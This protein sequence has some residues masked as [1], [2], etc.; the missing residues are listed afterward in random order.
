MRNS[1][2]LKELMYVIHSMGKSAHAIALAA[3]DENL[4]EKSRADYKNKWD[5]EQRANACESIANYLVEVA[6]TKLTEA[7]EQGNEP[8]VV[9]YHLVAGKLD[10]LVKR[11]AASTGSVFI[12]HYL[13][14]N[15][16]ANMRALWSGFDGPPS[17]HSPYA[18][19]KARKFDALASY[20]QAQLSV[21]IVRAVAN[22][23]FAH[24]R[25]CV[26]SGGLPDSENADNVGCSYSSW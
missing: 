5:Y 13:V 8:R 12:M 14:S 23:N 18:I 4:R 26:E 9:A 6:T 10:Y 7:V 3:R 19:A 22:N 25:E 21:E 20:I 17:T 15:L 24:V 1:L 16:E 2:Y 11:A